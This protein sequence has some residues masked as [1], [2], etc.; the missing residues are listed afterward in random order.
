MITYILIATTPF[1]DI[2]A[3][4]VHMKIPAS[5]VLTLTMTY[6][7]IYSILQD[8]KTMSAAY[9]LRN[10]NAKAIDLK[11]MGSF[12]GHLLVNSFNESQRV[13]DCMICRGYDLSNSYLRCEK[14]ETDN[15]FLLM[16]FISVMILVKVVV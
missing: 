16:M 8:A 4:L 15:V 6:R 1:D 13:Y 3:Q 9:L 5:F 10:P 14:F 2:T 7:Y 12:V 11:D